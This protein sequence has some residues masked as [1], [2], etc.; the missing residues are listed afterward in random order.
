[1]HTLILGAGYSGKRIA[2]LAKLCGS[3]TGTRREHAGIDELASL[4]IEGVQL[5]SKLSDEF[6]A[7]LAKTTHLIVSVAPNREAPLHDPMLSLLQP[8]EAASFSHL[9]WI[10]YLSTIGV[11][12]DYQGRWVDEESQCLS[13]QSRSIMRREAETA[14]QLFGERL[15]VPVAILRL[16]GIYGPERN[17]VRDALIGKARMLVKPHQVFNR[18]HVDDLARATL[19][20]AKQEFSGI[21]NITDDNPAPP[22]HVVQYAHALVGKSAPQAIDFLTADITPMARSFYSE[23]KRVLNT[24]SKRMLGMNYRYPNYRI[25]LSEIWRKHREGL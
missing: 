10:G 6:I 5:N 8:L 22:Q 16:S 21:L 9:K 23:N 14:W 13:A 20:A 3:V 12:G 25:A 2:R 15:G 24:A 19:L 18:I 17:A 11:Y 7:Q 4:G 1:M